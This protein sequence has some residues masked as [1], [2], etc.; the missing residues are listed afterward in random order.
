MI[1]VGVLA[2]VMARSFPKHR[3]HLPVVSQECTQAWLTG[4]SATLLGERSLHRPYCLSPHARQEVR[5]S[6]Q[7]HRYR[8]VPQKLL[9]ELWMSA[10]REQQGG[11][12]VPEVMEADV[13]Q[14]GPPQKG[15]EGA[16]TEVRWVD[17]GAVLRGED[18]AA[19]LVEGTHPFHLR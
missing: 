13:R 2:L 11:A 6:V 1:Q 9:N 4:F 10:L 16:V 15:L 18:E 8:G 12:G 5:V 17:G 7:G 19:G 3:K 14:S